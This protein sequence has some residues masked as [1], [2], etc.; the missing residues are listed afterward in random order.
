MR[1]VTIERPDG[2][3]ITI[4]DD[5]TTDLSPYLPA[6]AAPIVMQPYPVYVPWCV[7]VTPQPAWPWTITYGD[8]IEAPASTHTFTFYKDS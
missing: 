2:T 8:S 3:K 7:P 5:G 6:Q 1:K 4:E